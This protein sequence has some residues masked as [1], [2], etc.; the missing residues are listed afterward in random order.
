MFELIGKKGKI[1]FPEATAFVHYLSE[2]LLRWKTVDAKGVEASA[3]EV[4]HYQVFQDHLHFLNWIEQD[5]LTVS[6]IIDT[7]NG[8]VKA[9]WSYADEKSDRGQRSAVFIDGK[10]EFDG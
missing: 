3:E 2:T 5:G 4:I 1:T 8:T 6:Q 7:K 9:F 10:F